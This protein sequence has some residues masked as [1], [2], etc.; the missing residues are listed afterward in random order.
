M[1][2]R[3]TARTLNVPEL[4][5]T[6]PE[7]RPRSTTQWPSTQRLLHCNPW[8]SEVFWQWASPRVA[9][10]TCTIG[11]MCPRQNQ[12]DGDTVTQW[13]KQFLCFL[14]L[15]STW[16]LV[17]IH[18]HPPLLLSFQILLITAANKSPLGL[19]VKGIDP[20]QKSSADHAGLG[21]LLGECQNLK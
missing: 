10:V 21:V 9:K 3:W 8:L 16:G 5:E 2:K 19:D 17:G 15:H 12:H 13:H 20:N 1:F 14:E 18:K 11:L 4:Q 6:H 7:T